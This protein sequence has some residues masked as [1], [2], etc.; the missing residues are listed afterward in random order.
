MKTVLHIITDA[1]IGGA[2][3]L[4]LNLLAAREKYDMEVAL[5]E[6][7]QLI[8]RLD[9]LNVPYHEVPHVE[10][11]S[12]SVKGISPLV[13]VIYEREADVVHTH[14]AFSGRVAAKWCKTPI[15]HTRHCIFEP[16]PGDERF[17]KK[18]L[19]RFVNQYF[20][21]AI[22]AVSPAVKDDLVRTGTRA[23]QVTVVFNGTPETPVRT[24]DERLAIRQRY[25]V[26]QQ[27]FVVAQV[28]RLVD[29]KGHDYTLDAAKILQ[30]EKDIVFLLAGT[31]PI[32]AHLHA[33]VRDEGLTN[34]IM[35][36]FVEAV[37]DVTN[38]T[39][40]HLV[41][42]YGTE[43]CSLAK[44]EAMCLGIPAVVTDFGGNPYVITDGYNGAIVPVK[45][46]KALAEAIRTI[47]N[48]PVLCQ[49]LGQNAKIDYENR[50][51]STRMAQEVE[52]VYDK[53]LKR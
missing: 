26:P 42:S 47:K 7:S 10:A 27:A 41:A 17:R 12:V 8:P 3:I 28:A 13:R 11:R 29:V 37:E 2:G 14:A 48:D 32:E 22:I 35:P 43:T 1:N 31:G 20:A 21:D 6:G 19:Q 23:E 49:K 44:L 5:P 52:A 45:N 9:A 24:A 4:L 30:N 51:R 18:L 40:L 53:V 25:N 36:G 33:R 16:I 15:V 39:D 38:I 34:V 46:G 50:F